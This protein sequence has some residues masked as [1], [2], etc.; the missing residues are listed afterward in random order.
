MALRAAAASVLVVIAP[1][2]DRSAIEAAAHQLAPT[3]TLA[4]VTGP[5]PTPS[6]HKA[7]AIAGLVVVLGAAGFVAWRTRPTA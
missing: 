3:A 4:I 6:S 7:L 1:A 5:A 2:A